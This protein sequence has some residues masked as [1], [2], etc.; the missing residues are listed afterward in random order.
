MVA[1]GLSRL[2]EREVE[3][4]ATANDGGQLVDH[5][6]RHRPDIIVADV[7][8]P[9]M[10]G[11]DAMRRLKADGLQAK[12][13]FLTLHADARLVSEAIRAGASG[14]VLKQAAADELLEAIRAVMNGL[15]YLTPLV[16]RDALWAMSQ[17][18]D[19]ESPH[20]TPRQRDVLRLIAEGKRM[21]EIASDL[22][23]SVRTVETHK[24][25]MMQT[26]GLGSTADLIKFAVR[27]GIAQG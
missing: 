4:V 8:M 21:K 27:Q 16:T 7:N 20:L 19:Q 23:I 12:F 6:R 26:L 17:P 18:E 14:Y 11:L 13:I 24:Q 25:E 9:V 10:S 1:Q 15:L 22:G 5:A 3:V 2:L